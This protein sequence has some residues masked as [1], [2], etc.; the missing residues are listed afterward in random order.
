LVGELA[1]LLGQALKVVPA[2]EAN[3]A[4][5]AMREELAGG[6]ELGLSYEVV[7]PAGEPWTHLSGV[8]LPRLVYFLDCRG[9]LQQKTPG[10]FV[11]AFVGERL[12]FFD[13][14]V[15]VAAVAK[16]AGLEFGALREK[17][18]ER[19]GGP[20]APSSPRLLGG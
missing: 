15:F 17:W 5:G 2:A 16:H 19:S 8:A 1:E 6:S 18:G 11:S 9:A 12:Y 7:V 13:A 14:G 20:S 4:I 3:T 10:I